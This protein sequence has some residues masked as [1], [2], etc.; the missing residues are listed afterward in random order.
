M[1]ASSSSSSNGNGTV[2]STSTL[3]AVLIAV[4][5]IVFVLLISVFYVRWRRQAKLSP[6]SIVARMRAKQAQLANSPQNRQS[7]QFRVDDI[8]RKDDQ[9]QSTTMRGDLQAV[10]QRMDAFGRDV[11][12]MQEFNND[13]YMYDPRNRVPP[14]ANR[15]MS[16]RIPPDSFRPP[17][18][19][20]Y[21][22]RPVPEGYQGFNASSPPPYGYGPPPGSRQ[23]SP[24]SDVDAPTG[25]PGM[26]S[27]PVDAGPRNGPSPRGTDSPRD[28]PR[29]A[30]P[31]PRGADPSPRGY[32]GAD[33]SLIPRGYPGPGPKTGSPG[34]RPEP[35]PN[36]PPGSPYVPYDDDRYRSMPRPVMQF[37][38]FDDHYLRFSRR[39]SSGI[40]RGEYNEFQNNPSRFYQPNPRDGSRPDGRR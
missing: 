11:R 15:N 19:I 9:I 3:T 6:E 30:D 23:F 13:P 32:N 29:G 10:N 28:G 21:H 31:S 17:M 14:P 27:P 20:N 18:N 7:A 38:N 25:A 12:S 34:R 16:P 2:L 4:G 35:G 36:Q 8:Y 5:A 39:R 40:Y 26:R 1:G 24:R 33:P 37:E 22:Q